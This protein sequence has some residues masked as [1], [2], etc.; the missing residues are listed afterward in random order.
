MPLDIE[1]AQMCACSITFEE[2]KSQVVAYLPH[3]YH[4]QYNDPIIWE[5]IIYKVVEEISK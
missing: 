5:N 2:F 1:K 3:E 4:L